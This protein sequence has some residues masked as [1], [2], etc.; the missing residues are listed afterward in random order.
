MI[1]PE[2]RKPGTR[3]RVCRI[4]DAK[5]PGNKG[6]EVG[7]RGTIQVLPPGEDGAA[8]VGCYADVPDS[9]RMI[10]FAFWHEI[11]LD[12]PTRELHEDEGG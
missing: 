8:S 4:F 1:P 5:E 12:G 11:E 7:M 9:G 10:W 6:I 2:H 3:I